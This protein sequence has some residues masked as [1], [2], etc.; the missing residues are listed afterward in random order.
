MKYTT[1]SR[2]IVQFGEDVF[3]ISVTLNG[4]KSTSTEEDPSAYVTK[5]GLF[6]CLLYLKECKVPTTCN[7]HIAQAVKLQLIA[8]QFMTLAMVN[9]AMFNQVRGEG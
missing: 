6:L 7:M 3:V 1:E 4:P 9:R 2:L 5:N 8:S